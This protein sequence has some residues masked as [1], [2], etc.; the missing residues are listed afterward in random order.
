MKYLTA[1]AL[2]IS[3]C[4]TGCERMHTE[5]RLKDIESYIMDRP[6]SALA[7]LDTMNRDL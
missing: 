7:V 2:L 3:V 4:L 6:D 1:I 5:N